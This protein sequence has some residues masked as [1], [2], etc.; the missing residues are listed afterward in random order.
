VRG[1]RHVG[2]TL[3]V[4]AELLDPWSQQPPES[5]RAFVAFTIY[6]DLGECRSH[7]EVGRQSGKNKTLIH[8][9]SSE[10]DWVA[11]VRAWDRHQDRIAQQER[12][13][14]IRSAVAQQIRLAQVMRTKVAQRLIGA[15]EQNIEALDPNLLG[16]RDLVLWLKTAV[17]IERLALGIDTANVQNRRSGSVEAAADPDA[18]V[19][20]EPERIAVLVELAERYGLTKAT[21]DLDAASAER[22]PRST[23]SRLAVG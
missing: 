18:M 5:S 4:T 2:N 23:E 19:E 21:A 6:R 7:A 12:E 16:P 11:R 22:Q 13:H 10:H 20:R 3:I 9:W 15:P 17:E 14:A 1:N 8:R